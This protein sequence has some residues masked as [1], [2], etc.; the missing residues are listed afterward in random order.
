M[1]V[2]YVTVFIILAAILVVFALLNAS[3]VEINYFLGKR[4]M[5]LSLLLLAAL[6]SGFFIGVLGTVK[7]VL[8]ARAK[9]YRLKKKASML[10]KEI[11]NLRA[12]PVKDD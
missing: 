4:T 3:S 8:S 7:S 6:M 11:D 1:R 2:V 10:Q 12:M 5:P 9:A